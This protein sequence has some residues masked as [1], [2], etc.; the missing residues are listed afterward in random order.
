MACKTESKQIGDHT[1]SVTQWPPEK[2]LPMKFRVG[3]VLGSSLALLAQ[4]KKEGADAPKIV[5]EAI[6]ALFQNGSPDELAALI[7][8]VVVGVACD[9]KAVTST[10]YTELFAGD[11]LYE[12]YKV[13]I[14][15]LQVNYAG[16]M[17]G[18]EITDLLSKVREAV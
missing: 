3:K 17:N 10:S 5:A 12:V 18:Q 7:K 13:F 4:L 11:N 15:V 9:G 8:E 14:F 1:Y 6:N 16:F 2:A